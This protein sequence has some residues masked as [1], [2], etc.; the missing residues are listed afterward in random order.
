MRRFFSDDSP[1]QQSFSTQALAGGTDWYVK[2]QGGR[3]V[4]SGYAGMSYVDGSASALDLIQTS[5]AHYFQRPDV[6]NAALP[7][8]RYVDDGIHRAHPRGQECGQLA[9]GHPGQH[10]VA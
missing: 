4:F 3:Y 2:F 7:S 6:Q 5:S 1:L 9:V 10:R 8:G